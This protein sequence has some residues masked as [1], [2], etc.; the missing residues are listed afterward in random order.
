MTWLDNL[1]LLY[2]VQYFVL[3]QNVPNCEASLS[4]NYKVKEEVVGVAVPLTVF[5]AIFCSIPFG[6]LRFIE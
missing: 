4:I 2:D 6:V 3:P 1:P 5:D